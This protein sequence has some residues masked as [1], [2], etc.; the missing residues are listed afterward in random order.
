M[1]FAIL[2]GFV[3]VVLVLAFLF[4]FIQLKNEERL[5]EFDQSKIRLEQMSDE[6]ELLAYLAKDNAKVFERVENLKNQILFENPNESKQVKEY[7]ARI[8]SQISDLKIALARAKD[9]GT[10]SSA[11][12]II[13]EI[14]VLLIE[15][16]QK[17][18]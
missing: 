18:K 16:R 13:S 4:Y 2:I 6:L 14:E 9:R 1:L 7:D 15:R 10:Y 5:E 8:K 17:E 11:N 3:V 12:R